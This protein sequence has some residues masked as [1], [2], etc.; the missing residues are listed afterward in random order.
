[1]TFQPFNDLKKLFD[2]KY[3]EVHASPTETYYLHMHVNLLN[4]ELNPNCKSQRAEFF[5]VGI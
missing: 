3:V 1:M 5:L 2:I 4:A